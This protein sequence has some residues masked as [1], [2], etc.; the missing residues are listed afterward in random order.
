MELDDHVCGICGGSL[1]H[2]PHGYVHADGGDDDHSPV[3]VR[4]R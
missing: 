4:P 1:A 3:A 2:G